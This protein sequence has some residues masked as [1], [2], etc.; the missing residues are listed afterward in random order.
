MTIYKTIQDDLQRYTFVKT[1]K[2]YNHYIYITYMVDKTVNTNNTNKTVK[3][4]KTDKTVR[5]P[6]RAS[7]EQLIR[8]IDKIK[9]DIGYEEIKK[10]RDIQIK[11][12]LIKPMIF[13]D[14]ED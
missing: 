14:I 13:A 3:T 1:V 4:V 12:E 8:L 7:P 11:K 5:I 6:Y 10:Y 9:E 2:K